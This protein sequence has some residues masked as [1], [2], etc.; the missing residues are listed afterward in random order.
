MLPDLPNSKWAAGGKQIIAKDDFSQIEGAVLQGFD[1]PVAPKLIYIDTAT[2]RV[3]TTPQSPAQAVLN[4]FPDILHPGAFV[5]GGL[6]DGRY[7][8]NVT[9]PGVSCA[10]GTT[11]WGTLQ[12]WQFYAIYALAAN[13]DNTFALKAMPYLRVNSYGAPTITFGANWTPTTPINYGFTTNDPSIVGGLIYVLSGAS[14]GLMAPI[15]ALTGT[16]LTHDAGTPLTHDAGTPLTLVQGDWLVILPAPGNNFRLL[17]DIYVNATSNIENLRH[18][19]GNSQRAS[20]TIPP[21]S[22]GVGTNNFPGLGFWGRIGRV[23]SYK[24]TVLIQTTGSS[25]AFRLIVYGPGISYAQTRFSLGGQ[26]VDTGG[27]YPHDLTITDTLGAGYYLATLEGVCL[28][29]A[30]GLFS[31]VSGPA[32]TADFTIYT[33]SWVEAREL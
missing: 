14:R 17:G 23:L 22:A 1:L 13:A 31:L 30:D 26:V 9:A 15:T 5:D 19:D 8:A 18:S 4:G 20:L 6:S 25:T 16:T 12:P 27:G 29:T 28:P 3:E 11:I 21:I 33:G 10:L 2:V 32:T 24:F 7:R